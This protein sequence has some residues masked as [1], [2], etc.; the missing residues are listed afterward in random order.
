MFG[1]I[2]CWFLVTYEDKASF[3]L[4]H[5]VNFYRGHITVDEN[6]GLG[7]GIC[8]KSNCKR[9]PNIYNPTPWKNLYVSKKFNN[10]LEHVS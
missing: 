2:V 6:K 9:H 4:Q 10:S 8:S 7:C 3:C 1:F 5:L